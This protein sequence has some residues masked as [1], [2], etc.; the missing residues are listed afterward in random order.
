MQVDG[1]AYR[2]TYWRHVFDLVY[3]D[4]RLS[5]SPSPYIEQAGSSGGP[6]NVLVSGQS[7]LTSLV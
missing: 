3:F 4:G 6:A 7:D 2:Q 5:Y 1:R